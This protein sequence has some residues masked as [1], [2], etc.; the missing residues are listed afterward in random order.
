MK[1]IL[2][3]CFFVL[4]IG[5]NVPIFSQQYFNLIQGKIFDI[6][7]KQPVVNALVQIEF[8]LDVYKAQTDS[9]GRY[10]IK[11]MVRYIDGKY[12][13]SVKHNDYYDLSGVILVKDIATHDFGLKQRVK[14]NTELTDTVI[15]VVSL[16]GFASNNWT[17]LIDVSSSMG[18]PKI[19]SILKS[20]LQNIVQYF[21]AEDKITLMTFAS[22]VNEVLPPTSG[23]N[24]QQIEDAINAVKAGGTSQGAIA[25]DVAFK[26]ASKNYI[27]NGNNRILIFTD[28]M[29]T[30]GAKEYNKIEKIIKSYSQKDIDCSIFLFGNASSYVIKNLEQLANAGKGTFAVL[31]DE[32]T[33]KQKMIEE[34]QLVVEQ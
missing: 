15:P 21:R 9:L 10:V 6:E 30:S 26:N 12:N 23:N 1:R 11:T 27:E 2:Q 29:F 34:A 17:L 4:L 3:F 28:G 20:G 33:A 22:K 18:E 31:N 13:L 16:D 5:I 24:K 19:W 25:I 14:K 8:G 7:S 32:A